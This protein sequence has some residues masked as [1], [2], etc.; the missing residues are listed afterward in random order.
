MKRYA[1]ALLV[2]FIPLAVYGQR[3]PSS[4]EASS[5]ALSVS[6]SLGIKYGITEE[7]VYTNSDSLNKLEQLNWELTPL[8]VWGA[9]LDFSRRNPMEGFGFFIRTD[10]QAAFPGKTGEVQEAILTASGA[11]SQLSTHDNYTNGAWILDLTTGISFP[12]LPK[13]YLRCYG[14]LNY[15][16]FTL[17]GQEGYKEDAGSRVDFYGPVIGYSQTWLFLAGG[18][19]V[20]YPF[21]DRFCLGLSFQISPLIISSTLDDHIVNKVQ[22]TDRMSGGLFL[23]PRGELVFS[24]TKRVDLVL[25]LSYRILKGS[26]GERETRNTTRDTVVSPNKAAGAAAVFIDTGLSVTLHL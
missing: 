25:N 7:S 5:Y 12:I 11:V 16:K 20:H 21:L 4:P 23:E 14:A 9:A 15:M 18:F 10:L 22:Y 13:L 6:A 2:F 26:R 1:W 3:E 8:F 19:S 17:S 24:P